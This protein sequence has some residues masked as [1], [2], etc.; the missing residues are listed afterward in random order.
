MLLDLYRDTVCVAEG[1]ETSFPQ[2]V[3][4]ISLLI[5]SKQRCFVM[6]WALQIFSGGLVWLQKRRR[7]RRISMRGKYVRQWGEN[8]LPD[9]VWW[10]L[11]PK[12]GR[13]GIILWCRGVVVT[14]TGQQIHLQ[15]PSGTTNR[16]RNDSRCEHWQQRMAADQD[17]QPVS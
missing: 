12:F 17:L 7:N 9:S 15:W 6:L 4:R 1:R 16:N 3:A 11:Y 13:N 10:G 2:R 5:S 14:L 8:Y